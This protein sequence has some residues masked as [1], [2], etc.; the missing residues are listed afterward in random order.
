MNSLL[1]ILLR[2]ERRF[3]IVPVGILCLAT[4]LLG[5]P[6]L[7]SVSY[8]ISPSGV[9]QNDG[10][11]G[12]PW[13]T[14]THGFEQA[15]PGDTVFL[16]GGTYYEQVTTVRDG[17]DQRPIVLMG[18][19]NEIAV[20]DGTGA[21]FRNGFII[22]NDYITVIGVMVRNWPDTGIWMQAGADHLLVRRCEVSACGAGIDLYEGV[23]DF[24]IDSVDLRGFREES[25]GLDMT[26]HDGTPI[27]NGLISNSRSHDGGG[28]NCDGFA[29]GH[30][31]D[32]DVYNSFGDVRDVR[33]VNCVVYNV[34][35]GFDISGRNIVLERCMAYN[36]YYGGNYKLWGFNST[37][38]NCIGFNGGVN[39]E[40]DHF[41]PDNPN[42]P[43]GTPPPD[44]ALY[45][46]TFFNGTGYNI[47]LE[48]DS[49]R[50]RMHN[51][52]V[53][54][55]GNIGINFAALFLRRMYQGD[56]N[57][58]NCG[59]PFRMVADPIIDLSLQDFI[60]GKWTE[61][62]GADAHSRVALDP[63]TIFID[64]NAATIDLH[65]KAGSQAIDAGTS[66]TGATP[67][68]DF[69]GASRDDAIDIGAFE[70]QGPGSVDRSVGD[71]TGTFRIAPGIASNRVEAQFHL[72]R[73]ER[74]RLRLIDML[75]GSIEVVDRTFEAGERMVEISTLGIP[76]GAYLVAWVRGEEVRTCAVV[77]VH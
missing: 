55:G 70:Y 33:L 27:Y 75:G 7:H 44:V 72:L 31:N 67:T 12:N 34:G 77:I 19:G 51:C 49:C 10:S 5:G 21:N 41:V 37:L 9:D 25:H 14:I 24:I 73:P 43:A 59:N 6:A 46:C 32:G 54:G 29:L 36:T 38:I 56:Y 42:D 18:Y 20:I 39:V 57:I 17:I 50:L 28:G 26:S 8:Y 40:L 63:T 48:T 66:L 71:L 76:A 2:S 35:D 23:H 22:D 53:A 4:F 3:L 61:L 30:R 58:F 16:R 65:L 60:D 11:Y 68:I 52:I 13:R 64:T 62:S 69:D 1:N 74:V 45:N 47:S 15:Q